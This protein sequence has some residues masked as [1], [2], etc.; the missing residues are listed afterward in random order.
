MIFPREEKLK[1]EK[2]QA[3]LDKL[4]EAC[5]KMDIYTHYNNKFETI[6]LCASQKLILR[7]EK[8]E[9]NPN[10]SSYSNNKF[11]LTGSGIRQ[12]YGYCHNHR[13]PEGNWIHA[14]ITGHGYGKETKKNLVTLMAGLESIKKISQTPARIDEL[15][16]IFKDINTTNFYGAS[17][18]MTNLELREKRVLGT[19]IELQESEEMNKRED[20]NDDAN[21]FKATRLEIELSEDTV[22]ITLEKNKSSDVIFQI[23]EELCLADYLRISEAATYDAIT[24][25]VDELII[26][27]DTKVQ[28]KT[29]ELDA[30]VQKYGQYICY[31]E[32]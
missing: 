7:T 15:K 3:K 6:I 2:L 14:F 30:V 31:K 10:A 25:L 11:I 18:D 28:A 32:L 19:P 5:K 22:N 16:A 17:Y 13:R 27:V 4:T 1:Y 20:G 26:K 21:S 23:N 8:V 24:K 29:K 9:L 12:E